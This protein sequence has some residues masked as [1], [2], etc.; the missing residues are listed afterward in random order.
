[1][2]S[3]RV[4]VIG[5]SIPVP[6][7]HAAELT[8]W[9]EEFGDPLARSIP[10]HITLL[11]PFELAC[12]DL[13]AAREH[14]E[15]T[16]A[17][18]APFDVHLRGTA[19]FRPVSPVVFVQLVRGISECELLQAAIRTGPLR[20]DLNFPF[21]PHVTVAHDVAEPSLDRAELVLRDWEATFTVKGFSLY[22]HGADGVWRPREDFTFLQ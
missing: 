2:T 11:P 7:P 5:V 18:G 14:L 6:D 21:H 13:D 20:A 22:E 15:A 1:M 19:T 8:A 16:A 17:A 4:Q 10:P 9:R 12:A 3:E